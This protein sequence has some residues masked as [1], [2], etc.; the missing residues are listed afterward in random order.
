MSFGLY[1]VGFLIM[2]IGLGLGA[3]MMHVPP[4][5]IGVGIVTMIG[6]GILLG[7]TSTRR[8]DPS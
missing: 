5:W 8:P 7:V 4:K 3:H 2:I 6:L 1:M